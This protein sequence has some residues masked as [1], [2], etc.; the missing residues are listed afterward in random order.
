MLQNTCRAK[1][2]CI[3]IV[4]LRKVAFTF[5]SQS[6]SVSASQHN[7]SV[8]I[9]QST[10]KKSEVLTVKHFSHDPC[11]E[12][13]TAVD[14]HRDF[15]QNKKVQGI[16]IAYV[17]KLYRTAASGKTIY[18]GMTLAVADCC[19]FEAQL[20][21]RQL[22][23]GDPRCDSSALISNCSWMINTEFTEE[24]SPRSLTKVLLKADEQV[25]WIPIEMNT[26]N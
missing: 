7:A 18:H 17:G 4:K 14:E 15:V 12:M 13:T 21:E 11:D 23:Y 20:H 6:R 10:T 25:L 16:P 1:K 3:G 26:R 2:V 19:S 22:G 5:R 9:S 24:R 8:S